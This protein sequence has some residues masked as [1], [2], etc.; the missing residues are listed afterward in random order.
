[1]WACAALT[2]SCWGAEV[3]SHFHT[4]WSW[5]GLIFLYLYPKVNRGEFSKQITQQQKKKPSFFC[6]KTFEYEM[7][8]YNCDALTS[9]RKAMKTNRQLKEI[10]LSV[11]S[12][13][14]RVKQDFFFLGLKNMNVLFTIFILSVS[15][16]RCTRSPS[17]E[18]HIDIWQKLQLTLIYFFL[19]KTPKHSNDLI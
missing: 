17:T 2:L 7:V 3:P 13:V 11:S 4:A 8:S 1:M 9:I 10:F 6:F 14:V 12:E 16:A 19:K 5:A 18:F 15:K